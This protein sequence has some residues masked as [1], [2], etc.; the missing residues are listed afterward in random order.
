MIRALDSFRDHGGPIPLAV[1][2]GFLLGASVVMQ[3]LLDQLEQWGYQV[4][5]TVVPDP[6]QG[7]LVLARRA[8]KGQNGTPISSAPVEEVEL[9]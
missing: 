2:G 5:P 7:A 3:S 6:V 9:L 4:E 8:L 1:S